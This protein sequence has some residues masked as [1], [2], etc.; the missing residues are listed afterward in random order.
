MMPVG[1]ALDYIAGAIPTP[2]RT[3]S[4]LGLEWLA[5]LAAEPRRLGYRYLVEPWAL[6]P[7]MAADV[8]TRLRGELRCAPSR[9]PKAEG[10]RG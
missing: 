8:R 3:M 5:R 9:P 1:A 7:R 10:G 6:L 4:R 2:P